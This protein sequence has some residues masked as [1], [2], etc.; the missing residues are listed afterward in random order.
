MS[1][2]SLDDIFKEIG[3]A[4][5]ENDRCGLHEQFV[6]LM[7]LQD[8]LARQPPPD[9]MYREHT[10]V[11]RRGV[12]REEGILWPIITCIACGWWGGA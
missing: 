7:L 4:L 11:L 3:V 2:E 8:Q 12:M 6:T 5:V 10:H 9:D 1:A